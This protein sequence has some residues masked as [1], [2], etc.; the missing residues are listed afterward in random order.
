MTWFEDNFT[1]VSLLNGPL[2]NPISH[3][4]ETLGNGVQTRCTPSSNLMGL[5]ESLVHV[6]P[7]ILSKHVHILVE[8]FARYKIVA[9]NAR[10]IAIP[11]VIR[12][13]QFR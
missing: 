6:W 7:T 2:K 12:Y 1:E 3:H 4:W 10:G 5:W 13:F 9:I 8:C 11:L